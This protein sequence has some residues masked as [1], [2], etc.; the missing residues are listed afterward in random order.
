MK[1]TRLVA[2]MTAGLIAGAILTPTSASAGSMCNN[3]TYSS[4]S[5]RGTCSWNG[6]IN[7]GFASFSDPGSSSWNRQNGFGNPFSTK[8]NGFRW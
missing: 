8:R 1:K 6:G 2:L 3:G 4:N 5:G 7:R